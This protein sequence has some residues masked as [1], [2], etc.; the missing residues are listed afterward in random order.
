M[1]HP[2]D[3]TA[4]DA[5]RLIAERKL[6]PVELAQAAIER[7]ESLNP[8]INAVVA[9]DFDAVMQQA[10]EA[11]DKVMR[12]EPLGLLHGL[13]FGVKDMID[14]IGLPTTFGSEIFR[15]NIAVK[16]DAIVA[17]MRTEGAIPLGKTNNPDWSAGGNTINKVYGA[18]GNPH[19]PQKSAA[20]SSGGSAALLAARMAPLATGSDTGG[21]L[22]NPAAFCG[23]V[24]FRPSPGVV[25]GDTRALGLL[26]ISTSGPMARTVADTGLMLSV[27]AR[28]DRMDPYTMVLDGR[29]P[30]QAEDFRA[31]PRLNCKKFRFAV[32]EDFGFAPTESVVREAF[33][34]VIARLAPELGE[35]EAIHPDCSGADRI[36]S[37]LRGIAFIGHQKYLDMAADK[38]GPNVTVNVAEG[39]S[40]SARDIY[41][42]MSA[43]T[44]YYR[45]WQRFYDDWDFILCPAVTISP[46]DWRELYPTEIDGQ[47]TKSYYHWLAMAYASTLSGHPSITIPVGRDALGMPFGLQIIGR[48]HDDLGVLAIAADL[49]A[50]LKDD[51]VFSVP[52]VDLAGLTEAPPIAARPGFMPDWS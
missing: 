4:T 35:T 27:L 9:K 43:Q 36:F 32:T 41:E 21:S 6:S 17:A 39:L 1:T 20:G 34:K 38:V 52:S 13:P 12:D 45:N 46:R 37:V 50:M 11:E 29:T 2:A 5:V 26:P 22:R 51:P 42:A 30:W 49:E 3:L 40:F 23:V 25:P 18:T 31:L 33:Q 48:R 7:V 10:K 15:D 14:V 16:D 44:V 8:A 47:P 19:D 24:G 28:A